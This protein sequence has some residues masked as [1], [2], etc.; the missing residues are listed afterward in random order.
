[1]KIIANSK[2]RLSRPYYFFCCQL[3]LSLQVVFNYQAC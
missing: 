2:S 3:A 1:M